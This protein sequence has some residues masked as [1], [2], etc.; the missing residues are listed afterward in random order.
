MRDVPEDATSPVSA[1]LPAGLCAAVSGLL[2]FLTRF[3]QRPQHNKRSEI[4]ASASIPGR[5]A[6]SPLRGSIVNC[7]YS[8]GLRPRLNSFG[9]SG[10]DCPFAASSGL[11][12][13]RRSCWPL[14]A[15][16]IEP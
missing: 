1:K 8:G 12:V 11:R 2:V 16:Y 7:R 14:L 4:H 5:D 15:L 13:A 10:L 9:P 3:S 6:L